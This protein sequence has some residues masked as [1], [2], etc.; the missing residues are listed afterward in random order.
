MFRVAVAAWLVH[1]FGSAELCSAVEQCEV[2]AAVGAGPD[3]GYCLAP[4]VY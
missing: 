4:E 1:L 3:V 2:L